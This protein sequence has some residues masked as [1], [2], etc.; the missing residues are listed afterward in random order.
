M[1]GAKG[2]AIAAKSSDCG[3]PSTI[4]TGQTA[5]RSNLLWTSAVPPGQENPYQNEWNDLMD[6]I[7]N[8]KPYN[9]VK[10]GVEASLVTSMGRMAAHTGREVTYDTILNSDHEMAPNL[11]KLAMDSPAPLMADAKGRYPIPQPG[12]MTARE[13]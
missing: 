3:A 1:H 5:Q 11:D 9:E 8:D 6:A 2:L 4:F 7:R 10:R 13:F 12:I